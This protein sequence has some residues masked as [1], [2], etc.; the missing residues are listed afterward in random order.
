MII[1]RAELV[2]LAD[3]LSAL[4]LVRMA[5]AASGTHAYGST[6]NPALRGGVTISGGLLAGLSGPGTDLANSAVL[7][8]QLSAATT[9]RSGARCCLSS[10]R[11]VETME[12]SSLRAA[13]RTTRTD[14]TVLR[15]VVRSGAG[16]LDEGDAEQQQR[17]R[18]ERPSGQRKSRRCEPCSCDCAL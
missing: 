1:Q 8:E 10:D 15:A 3:R 17:H 5:L 12:C 7:S 14:A 6:Y 4:Q 13:I 2:S 18:R 11:N 16:D 9:M